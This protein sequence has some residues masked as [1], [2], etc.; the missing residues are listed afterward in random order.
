[1]SSC[2]QMNKIPTS[3]ERS[4]RSASSTVYRYYAWYRMGSSGCH[5]E[6]VLQV[7]A[8]TGKWAPS[9]LTGNTTTQ[10]LV[11]NKTPSTEFSMIEA[12]YADIALLLPGFAHMS[13][14]LT[15]TQKNL[16]HHRLKHGFAVSLRRLLSS[17]L[18]VGW[19]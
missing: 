2:R 16:T 1:M 11:P 15:S 6:T 3:T 8:A 9:Q 7:L 17:I 14:S 10:S 5:W 18:V 12:F 19:R 13:N 4:T